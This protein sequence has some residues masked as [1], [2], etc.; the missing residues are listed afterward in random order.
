MGRVGSQR[1]RQEKLNM[2]LIKS[3]V[4]SVVEFASLFEFYPY[5]L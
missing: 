2:Q 5:W 3:S 4:L 1:H